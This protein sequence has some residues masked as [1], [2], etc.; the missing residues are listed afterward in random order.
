MAGYESW[1]RLGHN[2]SKVGDHALVSPLSWVVS[3]L[4]AYVC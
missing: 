2:L 4:A 3:S 1:W